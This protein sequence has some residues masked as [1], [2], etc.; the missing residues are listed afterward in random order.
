VSVRE[1]RRLRQHLRSMH[2]GAVFTFA[3]MASGLA[4]AA[5]VPDGAR[6]IVTGAAI[7]YLKK[8]RG[9]LSAEARCPLPKAGERAAY[10]A[11]VQ[12]DAAAGD[13]IATARITWL[14]DMRPDVT[15]QGA[16]T[17]QAG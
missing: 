15:A 1:R 5:A 2:A 6:A 17:R 13:R 7:E 14:V 11:V 3:E 16:G 10:E 12:V 9:R 4:M 8:A